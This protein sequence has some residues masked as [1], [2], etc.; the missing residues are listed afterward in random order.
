MRLIFRVKLWLEGFGRLVL[1]LSVRKWVACMG[2]SLLFGEFIVSTSGGLKM[3]DRRKRVFVSRVYVNYMCLYVSVRVPCPVH[4][5]QRSF[6][7]SMRI[8]YQDV[9]QTSTL[10]TSTIYLHVFDGC[11]LFQ[12]NA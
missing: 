12:A 2:M 9:C 1:S 3:W 6:V 8:T 4:L 11:C 5:Q 7:E 10:T